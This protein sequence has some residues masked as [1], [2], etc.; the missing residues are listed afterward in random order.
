MTLSL[1]RTDTS[2]AFAARASRR[3]EEQVIDLDGRSK[4]AGLNCRGER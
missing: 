4:N 2:E 3:R 1:I